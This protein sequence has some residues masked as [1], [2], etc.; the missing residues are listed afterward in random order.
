MGTKIEEPYKGEILYMW[1]HVLFVNMYV[2]I[3]LML[4]ITAV[5]KSSS[6]WDVSEGLDLF[7][8][9]FGTTKNK[10]Q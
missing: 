4:I 7:P 5:L 8:L 10:P 9:T 3:L 2:N 1:K 6:V